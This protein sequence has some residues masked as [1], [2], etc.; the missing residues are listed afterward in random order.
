M[1]RLRKLVRQYHS[2]ASGGSA[3]FRRATNVSCTKSSASEWLK[4][5]ARP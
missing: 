5:N 2:G 4:P 3:S 1:A